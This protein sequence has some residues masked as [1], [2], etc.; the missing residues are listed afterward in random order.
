MPATVD[1]FSQSLSVLPPWFQA[2]LS[3]LIF[4]ATG[5]AYYQG[6]FKKLPGPT[7]TKDVIVPSISIADSQT[8][9]NWIDAL[10]EN[11]RHDKDNGEHLFRI[12]MLLEL[13]LKRL[14][15]V[16]HILHKRD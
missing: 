2:L 8:I 6:L 5:W 4:V 10:K 15:Q 9:Q 16:E 3:I 14:E 7:A 12:V 13:I 1:S 11:N